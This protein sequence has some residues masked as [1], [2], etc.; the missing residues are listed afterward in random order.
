M[1]VRARPLFDCSAHARNDAQPFGAAGLLA[2]AG[3][4]LA[5]SPANA[6]W[7]VTYLHPS[8]PGDSYSFA[9]S[10]NQQGGQISPGGFFPRASIWNGS[11]ASYVDL[12]PTRAGEEA[13]DSLIACTSGSHQVGFA[14]FNSDMISHASLWSGTAASWTSLHPAGAV[15]SY[16]RSVAGSQQAGYADFGT[17][18]HAGLW[19]GTAG[20]WIDLHPEDASRSDANATSGTQ[21]VGFAE[22]GGVGRASLWSGDAASRVDLH[23]A[24]STFSSAIAISGGTQAGFAVFGGALHAGV[25]TGSAG[26]WVDLHPTGSTLSSVAG[27]WGTQQVGQAT[28][29]DNFH[30]SLWNSTAASWAD[31]STFLTGS[32]RDSYASSIWS[33]GTTTHIAGYGFN[34]D[35]ARYEA[36]L[37]TQSIPAPGATAVL[38]LGGLLAARR[39]R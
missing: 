31:L 27:A 22:I 36:L 28:V 2:L 29:N 35:T 16:A 26:S 17:V 33:D 6:Q 30:A 14:F 8:T 3:L 9:V 20:S 21:Q 15:E 13:R 4:A 24:D 32:W 7:N 37:W 34:L 25:W 12:H 11:A 18:R 38:G 23:P 1:A 19:T 39:R 5:A 10:G